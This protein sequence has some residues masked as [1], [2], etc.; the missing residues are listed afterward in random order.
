MITTTIYPYKNIYFLNITENPLLMEVF[1]IME[2]DNFTHTHTHTHKTHACTC[3]D[4]MIF[5]TSSNNQISH[6]SE[7]YFHK[8]QIKFL[9][10][11]LLIFY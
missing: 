11:F 10:I 4:D 8:Y 6:R 2:K 3:T 1:C 7:C 5:I 9:N